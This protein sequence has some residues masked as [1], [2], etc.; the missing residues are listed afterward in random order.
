MSPEQV[1][2]QV[3]AKFAAS[4]Q[5]LEEELKNVTIPWH[6][7]PPVGLAHPDNGGTCKAIPAAVGF[8]NPVNNSSDR[9]LNWKR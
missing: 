9:K 3:K 5:R 1:I 2:S 8:I 7:P 6:V 4:T